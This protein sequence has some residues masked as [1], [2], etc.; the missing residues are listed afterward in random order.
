MS[1]FLTYGNTECLHEPEVF[2]RNIN[3]L[4]LLLRSPDV[5]FASTGSSYGYPLIRHFAPGIREVVVLRP[6]EEVVKSILAIDVSGIAVYD[7][8]LLWRNMRYGE[9]CLH[10]IAQSPDTLVVNHHDLDKESVCANIFEHCLGQDFDKQWWNSL[11]NQ[12]IQVDFRA[13]LRYYIQHRPE[14]DNFKKLCKDELRML[15]KTK[16]IRA[17]R[18]VRHVA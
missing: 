13:F 6:V 8:E 4:K 14:I 5:G 11:K 7:E 10:K 3:E 16:K 18:K 1:K 12:N 2:L 17:A 15:A 9:R